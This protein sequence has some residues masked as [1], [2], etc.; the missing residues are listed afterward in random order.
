MTC[1]ICQTVT[2]MEKPPKSHLPGMLYMHQDDKYCKGGVDAQSFFVEMHSQLGQLQVTR[3]FQVRF[4][5]L[6]VDQKE[7]AYS[8]VPRW[9]RPSVAYGYS[10]HQ[11]ATL[12][13]SMLALDG[14]KGPFFTI[15]EGA[16]CIQC[17]N[18]AGISECTICEYKVRKRLVQRNAQELLDRIGQRYAV[19]S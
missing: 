14:I 19:R 16:G 6:E 18:R 17:G 5:L 4:S 12:R 1:P 2:L 11:W 3:S 13:C 9:T 8:C 15:I 10:R 7:A